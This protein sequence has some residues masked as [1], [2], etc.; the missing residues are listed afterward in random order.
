MPR[1]KIHRNICGRAA[2]SVFKP[3]KVPMAQ[4][5]QLNLQ[6]DELEALRLVD[7][8]GLQQLQAAEVMGVSRQTLANILKQG[9]KKVVACLIEGKALTLDGAAEE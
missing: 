1:P 4:L 5:E 8:N 7:L 6:K 9:R 2:Y 3:N